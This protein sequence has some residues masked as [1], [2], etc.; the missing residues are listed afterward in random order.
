M[1]IKYFFRWF[2]DSFPKAIT[3]YNEKRLNNGDNN[4]NLLLL[5]LNGIIHTSCQKIYK[6]AI[7]LQFSTY[8]I[9]IVAFLNV[10]LLLIVKII[11]IF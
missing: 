7:P 8:S 4:Q 1:G 2:R 3:K 11:S 5:D 10:I 6:Y 9:T